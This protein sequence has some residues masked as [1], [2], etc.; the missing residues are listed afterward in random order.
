MDGLAPTVLLA[1][2]AL[3]LWL[4]F[5]LLS[6]SLSLC[7]SLCL[8]WLLLDDDIQQSATQVQMHERKTRA[9]STL[10]ITIRC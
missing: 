8:G 2:A 10:T 1:L 5:C 6:L 9:L 4:C 3:W 7:L